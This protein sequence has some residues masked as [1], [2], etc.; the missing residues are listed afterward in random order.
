MKKCLLCSNRYPDPFDFCPVDG[1]RLEPL[2]AEPDILEAPT[3]PGPSEPQATIQIRTLMLSLSILLVLG[4]AAFSGV[5]LYQ[6][7]KP[8]YGSLV[9]K[10]TPPGAT[11]WLDGK[12][13]GVSP[14]NI[15]E[16][17][18]GSHQIKA[19]LSGYKDFTQQV[20]VIPYSSENVHWALEPL[21]AHLSNEQ[22][23]E[24]ESYKKKLETAQ[25]ENI[26]LP[27][28]DDY[29]V[30]YFANRILAI[31]PAN[32]DALEAKKQLSEG[33][34]RAADLAYAREDWL[35][36]EKQYKSLA[37]LYP[38][39]IAINE[40]LADL[41][42][43]IDASIKDREKQIADWK[44]K[45]EAALKA[46]ALVPPEKD[47]VLDALNSIQRLDKK[48]E[49]ART[50]LVRVKEMLQNR[51]DTKMAAGDLKGA[52]TEFRLVAQYFP[53]DAY[54]RSR[55]TTID[56]RLAEMAQLEQ[57]RL[58]QMQEEQKFRENL[59]N[60]RQSAMN[61]YRA[62]SYAKSI[63]E[64]QEYLKLEPGNDE[65]YF[66]IGAS[67]LEQKQ[68]DTAI[69]NFEKSLSI[70]PKNGLAHLNL[71]ILYDRH[72]NDP[73]LATEHLR[74]VKDLGGVE[75][76]TP[77]RIQSMIQ[78]VQDRAQ[79]DAM[80]NTPFA[81]DH[82]HTFSSCRGNLWMR[83]GGVEYKTS[84]TD[85]SFYESYA[86]LRSLSVDGDEV[87]IRTR[88]NKKYNFQLLN[89]DDGAKVR[90]LGARHMQVNQ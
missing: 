74:K 72:R 9:I 39:D 15:G 34:Q 5:F 58:Q 85:H 82:K 48:N 26:L 59:V 51:G 33:L 40:R 16:L 84:E 80:Q 62:G 76:Y 77:E 17:R 23:A 38:D 35:E 50:T 60:L 44:A 19:T 20:D 12:E 86:G 67:Y 46:G 69:L 43:K 3:W 88:N 11:I 45:A 87:S 75:R 78:D 32:A 31:D 25:K 66:Y 61:A 70:N 21:V 53:D 63:A 30:L 1:T 56:A 42:S 6:Y 14:L 22:L 7:L 4:A 28:P 47:N 65:A 10:T 90:R 73:K 89:P 83:E 13:R 57:Q 36:A 24:V 81:A 68:F 27:P 18:S 37:I 29:N 55:L 54:A 64:W 49:Y 41:S 2:D 52:R 79:L 8:K 71:G